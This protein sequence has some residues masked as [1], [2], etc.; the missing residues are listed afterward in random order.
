MN[1][2]GLAEG[3]YTG[4]VTISAPGATNS[5]LTIPVT[6]AVKTAALAVTPSKLTFFGATTA[7]PANQ[8]ASI[9][10]VGS[11]VL[12]WS[13]SADSSWIGLGSAAGTAPA[14]LSISANSSALAAGSYNGNVTIGSADVSN[15]PATIPVSLQVGSLNFSDNFATGA[16]NWTISPLGNAAGW[17]A[18]NN[19]YSYNGGGH[20]QSFA[21]N[22]TWANYTVAANF[23]L[24]STSDFPGGL[25]GRLNTSTGAS[26]AVWIYP[27]EHILKLYRIGQWNIDAGFS[28]LAQSAPVTTDTKVHS[29][30]LVFQGTQIQVYYDDALAI[31][32]TDATY[33]QGAIALDVS[34]QPIGFSNVSVIGF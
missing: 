30:R 1:A 2:A 3:T 10:N 34:N 18:A 15:G 13:A 14:T 8:N 25:R 22:S 12:N 29:L 9:S 16:G 32:A 21:G 5:P 17:S 4:S 33:S 11:G 27:N 31:Q 24:A 28:L 26:Y 19:V 6:L 20:T 23:Q 7:N